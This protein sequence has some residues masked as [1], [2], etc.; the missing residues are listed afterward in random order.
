MMQ[1]LEDI[2]PSRND[3][4]TGIAYSEVLAA[5]YTL[6]R[7]KSPG[8]DGISTETIQAG[9]EP[10]LAHQIYALCNKSWH[11]GAIPKKEEISVILP[12]IER[13]LL[14]TIQENYS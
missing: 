12:T 7:N 4:V 2:V 9:G 3:E 6:K 5:T 10:P 13:S 1:E 11:E 14:S 8:S